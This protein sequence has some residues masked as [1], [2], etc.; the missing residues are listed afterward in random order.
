MTQQRVLIILTAL[1]IIL[2]IV[3][4]GVF[5]HIPPHKLYIIPSS[6][7]KLEATLPYEPGQLASDGWSDGN[8]RFTCDMP[9]REHTYVCTFDIILG[10]SN[11]FGHD[12][13]AYKK[14]VIDAQYV[15]SAT[16][17][18]IY[19]RNYNEAYSTPDDGNSAKFMMLNLNTRE[20]RGEQPVT[21]PLNEFSV[22]DWWIGQREL[23]RKYL[24]LEFSNVTL[25]GFDFSGYIKDVD[26]V[27]VKFNQVYFEG[28]R[29]D[30]AKFH[31]VIILSWVGFAAVFL[32][33]QFIALVARLRIYGQQIRLLA[34]DKEY[35]ETQ[36]QKY[37]QLSYMDPLTGAM[38][39]AGLQQS[40][41]KLRAAPH[42]FPACIVV[43]DIDHFK[44]INDT[45]GHQVGDLILSDICQILQTNIR[46]TDLLARWGG[47]E[48][49]LVIPS[50][51]VST[52]FNLT[53]KIRQIIATR[54]FHHGN[55]LRVT[56][57]FGIAEL[58]INEQFEAAFK[59]ADEAL[60]KAKREGRNCSIIA[61]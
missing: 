31:L 49:V 17:M 3:A 4:I 50:A 9:D 44:R 59:R 26:F 32:I 36:S 15:G 58:A 33:F 61:D 55:P 46:A 20:L 29:I 35:F 48:F 42:N 23:E 53:E 57:S 8:T 22:A 30:E 21:I 27:S 14:L 11:V 45:R 40:L 34:A 13:S 47:E 38:N 52:A 25:M 10:Q 7:W 19:F 43:L 1:A 56:C 18:R 5:R 28:P 2:T 24:P 37:K 41:Q 39:R 16:K 6:Q 60:Y 54:E 12:L 51:R